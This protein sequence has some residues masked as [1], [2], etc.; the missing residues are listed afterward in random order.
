MKEYEDQKMRTLTIEK[1]ICN[2]NELSDESKTIAIEEYQ[3]S[4]LENGDLSRE[5]KEH[6]TELLTLLKVPFKT[7][8]FSLS[9][10][11]GDGVSFLFNFNQKQLL[12][13][14]IMIENKEASEKGYKLL[15]KII[16]ELHSCLPEKT[17]LE[18]FKK[19]LSINQLELNVSNERI[20]FCYSHSDTTKTSLSTILDYHELNQKFIDLLKSIENL[21]EEFYQTICNELE[22]SGYNIIEYVPNF[23]EFNELSSANDWEYLEN[24]T[25]N[26]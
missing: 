17:E 23:Q 22:T 13:F 1:T 7:I 6:F 26:F 19:I 24:G 25:Q 14:I 9:N 16:D 8:D 18:K 21:I 11:Q 20:N 4:L 12:D 2:F 10:C 3:D 5:V 15:K